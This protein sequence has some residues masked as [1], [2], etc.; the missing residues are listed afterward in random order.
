MARPVAEAPPRSSK[1]LR[2]LHVLASIVKHPLV[3][4]AAGA[5]VSGLLVPALTRGAQ[6]HRQAL[7]IKSDLVKSMSAAASPFL[8][9]T[10]ANELVYHGKVPRS[11]DLAYQRWV[12]RDNEI[13]AQ[14]RTY[15]PDEE[16]TQRWSNF[17]FRMRDL[18]FYFRLPTNPTPSGYRGFY[19]EKLRHFVPNVDYASLDRWLANPTSQFD[20]GVDYSVQQLF[21]GFSSELNGI[22]NLVIGES[23][24]L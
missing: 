9:A 10:L 12:T 15:F 3:L 19:V 20:P 1:L 22:V 6:N 4:L 18:Y 13:W 24:R 5:V 17:S 16:A 11:Y 14:L 21:Y 2:V 8:A 23:Q 7:E